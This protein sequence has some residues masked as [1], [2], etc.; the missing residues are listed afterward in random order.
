MGAQK[1]GPG[2]LDLGETA[3]PTEF[4]GQVVTAELTPEYET[5]DDRT[6]L[7][8]DV[9]AGE[10]SETWTL[11]GEFLQEYMSGSLLFWCQENA[12]TVV[13]F[14]FTP[15]TDGDLTCTGSV[16]VR[17]VKVGGEVKA[18]NTTEFTFPVVGA[19]AFDDTSAV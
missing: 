19:V 16:K 1:L 2:V 7:S 9:I 12:G 11:S 13:P 8:G 15:R 10:E 14:T 5:E 4:G 6:V 17:A 18:T 3:S